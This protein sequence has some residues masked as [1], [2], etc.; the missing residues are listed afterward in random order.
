MHKI[1]NLNNNT[2]K[3]F[4]Q[5]LSLAALLCVPWATTAQNTLTV[6]DGTSNSQVVPFDGYNADAAQHNQVLYPAADLTVMSG[7]DITQMVFYIDQSQ[8]NGTNTAADRMGTWTV[9]LGETSATSLTGLDNSTQLTQ[10]YQGYFDCSTG[11]LTIVFSDSYRYNGGNLLVD[12]NHAAASWNRWYFLGIEATGAA[13][14]SRNS[15]QNFLPKATFSYL[16][17]S[18]C[19]KPTNVTITGI[20]HNSVSL[21][22]TGN[23][24]NGAT[25]SVMNG[26]GVVV[27][28]IT[29]TS[30]TITGLTPVT[31]YVAGNFTV[32]ADCGNDGVSNAANVPAFTTMCEPF[33]IAQYQ[34]YI[35]S[36]E[37]LYNAGDI[38]DCWTKVGS[39][40]VNVQSSTSNAHESTMYLR[41]GG[42]T[43]NL[44]LLPMMAEEISTLQLKFWTRP[45]SNT[46][47]SCGTFSVGYVTNSADAST[48]VE[49]AN[50]SYNDWASAA[51]EQKTVLFTS[52]PAGARMAMRHNANAT[53][54]Y[55]YV[56]DVTVEEAPNCLPVGGI[57]VSNITTT[58]ATISWVTTNAATATYTISDGANLNVTTAA[59]ATSYTLTTLNP[60]T[61]Y[62][63]LTI[64]ANCSAQ[65]Q[66]D[67]ATVPTFTTNCEAVASISENFDG[68]T[69]GNNVLPTCWKYI[70]TTT[71][72]SY[73]GYPKVYNYGAN[74]PSNCLYFYSYFSTY[75][76]YDPQDQYAI[77]PE[78][79]GVAGKEIVLNAKGSSTAI[80]FKIGWMTDPTDAS[81]F[82]EI[83]TQAL[84]TS[85]QEFTF[86]VPANA[87]G[88]YIAIMMEGANSTTTTKTVYIDDVTVQTPPSCRPVQNITFTNVE[89]TSF[90]A[91]WEN[92]PSAETVNN[93]Q[94]VLS[95]NRL[96]VDNISANPIAVT[97][98]TKTFTELIR[99]TKYYLY[100]RANCGNSDG[101]SAW[102]EDSV[103]THGLSFCE[104]VVVA[105]GS[106]TNS[107]LPLYG[108][109]MDDPVG[110]QTIYPASMLTSLVG[111]TISGL[112][113][114]VSSGDG[115]SWTDTKPLLVK[116]MVVDEATLTGFVDVANATTVFDGLL[117]GSAINTTNGFEIQFTQNFTYTGGNL[118]IAMQANPNDV[119]GY[120]SVTFLGESSTN[121]SRYGYGSSNYNFTASG[122]SQSFLPKVDFIYCESVEA[123]PAVTNVTV[124]NIDVN[125]ATVTWEASTGDYVEGYYIDT[126]SSYDPQND[127]YNWPLENM[128]YV[129]AGTTTYNLTGLNGFHNYYV[130]ITT[131]CGNQDG[132]SSQAYA[133]FR[134]ASE[135]RVP[136]NITSTITGK[137]T[138][139]VSWEAGSNTQPQSYQYFVMY[140][141]APDADYY[142]SGYGEPDVINNAGSV[143]SLDL[144]NLPSG[145]YVYFFLRNNCG[146]TGYSPWVM[147]TFETYPELPAVVNLQATQ[148]S[149]SAIGVTWERNTAQFADETQWMV[150][151]CIANNCTTNYSY[152]TS[153]DTVFVGLQ[154]ETEYQ[155]VVIPVIDG[156]GNHQEGEP[157]RINVTT[158]AIPSPC[159][160]IGDGTATAYLLNTSYGN[161]YSQ[162]IYTAE[163]L[164]AMGYSAGTITSVA[165]NYTGASSNYSKTQSVYIGATE[166]NAFAGSAASNFVQSSNLTLVYGPTL[167]SYESGWRSYEFTTPFVWD[168]VSNIVVAMLSNSTQSSASGWSAQGTVSNAYRTIYRYQDN[169]VIDIDN[170]ASVNSGYY[171]TTRPNIQLCFYQDPNACWD[172]T[173]VSITNITANSVDI[174]WLPG[175]ME[176]GWRYMI[177]STEYNPAAQGTG[178]GNPIY[179]THFSENQL[180][181]DHDYLFWI[182]P[183]DGQ[184]IECGNWV[185][186]PFSTLP[187]CSLPTLQ[188]A[189]NVTT[190]SATISAVA[191][192]QYG[193]PSTY[194]FRYWISGEEFHK[195]TV[196]ASAN[197][198]ANLTNL[199]PNTTYYYEAMVSCTGND[200]DSRWTEPMSFTTE[201][202]NTT[203]PYSTSFST[204]YID[205]QHWRLVNG[206]HDNKWAIGS[207]TDATGNGRALYV[208]N[209]GGATNAYNPS[210]NCAIFAYAAFNNFEAAKQYTVDFDWMAYGESS[211]DY[212]RAWI[213]PDDVTFAAGTS[214]PN[215][216]GNNSQPNT[217]IPVDGGTNLMVQSTWQ[218]QTAYVTV[219]ADGAYKLVFMWY[220]DNSLGTNP[221]AAIDN[222][223][224]QES[225]QYTA[226]AQVRPEGVGIG[227]VTG[228]GTFYEGT[229]I[230]FELAAET[231]HGYGFLE[232]RDVYGNRIT[233]ES[234]LAHRVV[235]DTMFLAIYDSNTYTITAV[236]ANQAQGTAAVNGE[237]TV[238]FN[239][240]VTIVATPAPCYQFL[241]W[242]NEQGQVVSTDAEY[243]VNAYDSY[244]F[245]ANFELSTI[246]GDTTAVEC[247]Q[248]T[249]HDN[250]YYNTPAQAPIFVY[251]TNDGCDSTVTLNL[252][253]NHS[254]DSTLVVVA[255]ESYVMNLDT[256][257]ETYTET[258]D[259][260]PVFIFQNAAGC[261][262]TVTLNLTINNPVH[263]SYVETVCDSYTWNN[264]EYTQSGD[265]QYSHVDNNGC[266][267]V[268]TLHLTVNYSTGN[269]ETVTICNGY[270]WQG[271]EVT[272]SG[273]YTATSTNDAGCTHIDTLVLTVN[274][275]V[276]QAFTETACESY[277]WNRTEYTQSGDYTYTHADAN[278]CN[279]TDT[280]HL[281]INTPVHQSYFETV[282]DSYTWNNTEYTQSGDYQYSHVDNNGCTQ[283]DTLHLTVNYSTGNTETVTICN[284]YVWQGQEVTESGTYTATS[285]NDAGCTHIDTLVLTV[286]KPVHQAFTETACES[287]TWNR[288]E[289]TQSGDYTY[290]HADANNCNQTDTLHL[291]CDSYT[292][293]NTEYTQSGDY[294]YSHTDNN[295]CTQ[296]DTLH[297]T[298][299]YSTGNTETVTIC[300]GYVWQ[301]QEITESGTYTATSTNDAGCTHIDT[302]LLTVNK[303]VHQ[304]FTEVACESY[305]WNNT[306]YTQ[307]GD[308]TY[309]HVDNNNCTQVDT[310]HLTINNAVPET[311]IETVCDSYTW[312]N[313]EYTQSGDYTYSHTD[314]NG[315]TQVDTLH[316]TVNYSTEHADTVTIC[317]G[318]VWQ[319]EEVTESGVYTATSTND[320]GCTHIETLV[321][322]VNKPQHESFTETACESYTWNSTEYTQSGDYRLR[323]LHL[324][325]HRV[326]PERR[327][328][329]QPHRQ[330][331]LHT[332]RHAAPDG[333][334]PL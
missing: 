93:F 286:N 227:A 272:E 266:T 225:Q 123:C 25:Y 131:K 264:T 32:V 159:A 156:N 52:A 325:Q 208:S 81:T 241:N 334:L 258:P 158:E 187:T 77:L 278:N 134:T 196:P 280:L 75:T 250:T 105:S 125:S 92:H 239:K 150:G 69:T 157:T 116:M 67:P 114:Y 115:N 30:Y 179:V 285:T 319:G 137:H 210:G 113:Y 43:S 111:K 84:T 219:P 33:D 206:T 275:P 103:T 234:V 220:N 164:T 46:S 235:A 65:E 147:H 13:Y 76:D 2:M 296:V 22:W 146:N 205:D 331:R 141:Q 313:T 61:T 174:S 323:Q 221:P 176:T 74:S 148:V 154:P 302:L 96:D 181:A 204:S 48:F 294:T 102:I 322:T 231:P 160:T 66:S 108:G 265:Y 149:H 139:T 308:Y 327:L 273:T 28:G 91:N 64:T 263:Q 170:L 88:N 185:S 155:I 38:P 73:K 40:T 195:N 18:A 49:V 314:N 161:T 310:L 90:T 320:F 197:N 94:V 261:D 4:L 68:Y 129:P 27:S 106:T 287:Y 232:W 104:D 47:S 16:T 189:T 15:G 291:V 59:G 24:Y 53:N 132:N 95:E 36:F 37:D 83:A 190:T 256:H 118:L 237:S 9:S 192:G 230:L 138:A 218:H 29:A 254:T 126:V 328:H 35:E 34:Q 282:C 224:I 20:T 71:Y 60:A 110:T 109:Y 31:A 329:L 130:V 321:L 163:E 214:T 72:N 281:T 228:G 305:T 128:A 143:T 279:Q 178:A 117:V 271:Q 245:T 268:D 315:C 311:I 5:I 56:D 244:T 289:Y 101:Y 122:T 14:T 89:R 238:K 144:A 85:Y 98:P 247:D 188:P 142:N 177:S 124:S 172:V 70:N 307:S 11:T 257:E 133:Q 58:G 26:N 171:S 303:P 203:L 293:N 249:W 62:N 51:H 82:T 19:P 304:A 191:N 252:T 186:F 169:T 44:I 55:W 136:E 86:L 119:D 326:H 87:T 216:V 213:V 276:H 42:S 183:V 324:E 229:D 330:Q 21:S 248:F 121:A 215:G 277:T 135:C 298:V 45:E 226:T 165:F 284:G 8:N 152:V 270:V 255:C 243:T 223:S 332:G 212:L 290:T 153:M 194:T 10:V 292:W 301:G 233:G 78:M 63:N 17:P 209:D 182:C 120:S 167:N 242:T 198:T 236:T 288:T 211:Y 262:S 97:G 283:V 199:T 251:T 333:E 79:T 207:A 1:N 112:H 299:N 246:T 201:Y 127:W 107:Y 23:G 145:T 312:N 12:L 57:A 274:K 3:K 41:F 168:G 162:H 6:A 300:N 140:G 54:W 267:Q 309:S 7:K 318:Y 222:V 240:P 297:L 39:G 193:T 269:T 295:G 166:L 50:Y 151:I 260:M 202:Q 253:I 184:G 99:D 217:W 316:L 317:N 200:G 306:E 180:I 173:N 100:V 259:K 80:S 175:N